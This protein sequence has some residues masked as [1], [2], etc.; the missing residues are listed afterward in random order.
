MR[1]MV[2]TRRRLVCTCR[3]TYLE[4][5]AQGGSTRP[6]V[7]RLAGV[8]RDLAFAVVS[9]THQLAEVFQPGRHRVRVA[10]ELSGYGVTI[11][12]DANT[13]SYAEAIDDAMEQIRHARWQ[14]RLHGERL[15]AR[16]FLER[17]VDQAYADLGMARPR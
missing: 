4:P 14:M 2:T 5:L 13:T 3:W 6:D 11:T 10:R 17:L 16:R 8:R 7:A 1:M 9:A 12:I 15:A